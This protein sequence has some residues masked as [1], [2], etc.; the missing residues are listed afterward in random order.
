MTVYEAGGVVGTLAAGYVSDWLG[1]VGK[2]NV[3]SLLFS[4]LLLL[5]VHLLWLAPT[6]PDTML[7]ASLFVAGV[8]VRRKEPPRR[9]R[10]KKKGKKRRKKLIELSVGHNK[11]VLF[12][13]LVGRL[14]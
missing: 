1:G 6:M 13:P 7:F 11:P 10:E 8:A 9:E 5:P 14:R 2:R 4:A 3:S 12:F